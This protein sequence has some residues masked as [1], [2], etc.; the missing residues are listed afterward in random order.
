[1]LAVVMLIFGA[2]MVTKASIQGPLSNF[3]E[4]R[5][6]SLKGVALTPPSRHPIG[7]TRRTMS[8]NLRSLPAVKLAFLDD[9]LI[10]FVSRTPDAVTDDAVSLRE[11]LDY[12][13]LATQPSARRY[14]IAAV[15]IIEF[16]ASG[17]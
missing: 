16:A 13:V 3:E 12:P 15:S 17:V 1:M 6:R 9:D 8:A 5:L 7:S 14:V 11:L 4:I 2:R 10:L